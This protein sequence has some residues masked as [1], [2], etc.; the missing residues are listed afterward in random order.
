MEG[1]PGPRGVLTLASVMQHL[2][3]AWAVDGLGQGPPVDA[4]GTRDTP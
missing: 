1:R 3:E 4:Q 2:L